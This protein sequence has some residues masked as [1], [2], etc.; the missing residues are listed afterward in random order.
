MK[1]LPFLESILTVP[2]PA[3]LNRARLGIE[4]WTELAERSD[5]SDTR[6]FAAHLIETHAGR[7][8]IEALAGNSPFLFETALAHPAALHFL[9]ENGPDRAFADILARLASDTVADAVAIDDSESESR[10]L[11]RTLRMV[12]AQASLVIAIADICGAWPVETI[13]GALSTLADRAIALSVSHLLKIGAARGEIELADPADPAFESGFIVLGLGKLGGQDLNYSSDVDLFLLFDDEK[14][15]YR[16]RRSAQEFFVR[17]SH[18]L[19]ALLQER[20]EHGYVFRTDLRLR[21]DP[22]ATPPVVSVLAAETYYESM[23]QNWERAALIKARSVAG[24][25]KAG[26]AFIKQLRPFLWRKNLDFAAIRDIHSIKRQINAHHG[27]AVIRVGGHNVKLGRGGIREIEF[28]VQTQQLIWGGHDVRLRSPHTLD[29][30][31]ALV[32]AGLVNENVG[33]EMAAAYR[34]LRR[35]EHRLQMIDDRQT[36]TLPDTAEGLRHVALFLGYPDTTAFAEELTLHLTR[37]ERHYAALFEGSSPLGAADGNLVFTGTEDDPETLK[38]LAKLGFKDGGSVAAVVR[39]WHHGRYRA[40]RSERAREILTELMPALLAALGR[41]ANPNIAFHN[42][43]E[44]LKR[45]PA[46]V[47]LFSLL[48]A[49]P[50]MPVKVGLLDL[51]AEIMGNAPR[52]A[53]YLSSNPALLDGVLVGSFFDP[54]PSAAEMTAEFDQ[55][56]QQANDFEDILEIA[57]RFANDLRFRVG[58]QML[59]G[60]IEIDAAGCALTDC[61]ETMVR[62]LFQEIT[63]QFARTHGRVP[64]GGFA[65]IALGKLGGREL[66]ERSDLDFVFVYDADPLA[67]RSDGPKPLAIPDYYA[68]LSQRLISALSVPTSEGTLFAVDMRLRPSGGA[69]PVASSLAAFVRYYRDQAWTWEFMA[70]TRARVIAGD[71]DLGNRVTAAIAETI[72]R[73]RDSRALAADVADMRRRVHETH[74]GNSPWAVKYGVGGLVDIE[75]IAQYLILA[76]AARHPDVVSSTTDIAYQRLAAVKAIASDAASTLRDAGRLWRTIQ[77]LLRLTVEG[78]FDETKASDGLK[79]VLAEATGA[80]DFTALMATMEKTAKQVTHLYRALIERPAAEATLPG[81]AQSPQKQGLPQTSPQP[82]QGERPMILQPGDLAPDFSMPTADGG[83][84]SLRDLRGRKTVLY[85]YP[86]DDTPGCTREACAFRDNLPDFAKLNAEI[87]GVSRDDG[88]S[89]R[90]FRDKYGLNFILASDTDGSVVNDYG[91]WKEKNNYG[92]VYWGIER[93]TYLIDEN[94]K[95]EKIWLR[96]QVDGHADQIMAALRGEPEPKPAAAPAPAPAPATAKPA[97]KAKP[98]AKKAVKKAPAKKAKTA[99]SAAKKPAKKTKK[100]A[101]KKAPAKKAKKTTKKSKKKAAKKKKS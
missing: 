59:K 17:L 97:V 41:T 27:G 65:V 32:F 91:V 25:I 66:T 51:V 83:T 40:T 6:A 72:G 10:G 47:Q 33:D 81:A 2:R 84:I 85:F 3:D 16:G 42:F 64:G 35:V 63:S 89:H 69:G 43:D 96:V 61:A 22:G 94:G 99:K 76:N 8:L 50:A 68:R 79:A 54:P 93:S 12:K 90:A 92:K 101:K 21:P 57:R 37:V 88:D 77:G 75:F 34:F 9:L 71:P 36:H 53:S 56:L 11:S 95:I 73:S 60:M 45:L 29:A 39:G 13:T 58:V 48:H 70:L 82:S 52:L 1:T 86:K 26:D 78:P 18:A 49:N 24:D 28:F 67:E 55:R 44:F 7:A 87:V 23:G 46:G 74:P 15:R 19:V 20:T 80:K 14:V 30:L 4:R 5:D 100:V 38:T 31:R 98:K 62:R